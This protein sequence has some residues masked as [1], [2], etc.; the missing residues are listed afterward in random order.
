MS[1]KVANKH[2]EFENVEHALTASEAFI[3][4]YQ[5]QMLYGLG[6]IAVIV[7]GFL[8]ISNFY[9]K[10]RSTEAANEMYKSQM[11]FSKDSF[12]LALDGDGVESIGFEAISSDYS[13]T[14]SGN[15][16]KAY[17]G[18]CYYH[19]GKYE[20]AIKYLNAYDGDDKY[21]SI[22]VVGLIGDCYA[23]LGENEKAIKY[24]SN[25]A[26]TEND[27]L[28]PFYLKKAAIVYETTGDKEKA[29]ANYL[30]IK[31]EYPLSMESQDIDKYIARIQ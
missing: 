12:Q 21:F 1:N 16:A 2:D 22:T 15:L 18:I 31:E 25:A 26:G 8:A 5:K 10:P 6:A 9:I 4:K 27:V 11:Y 30:K 14:A 20:D 19:L 29:L 24:F 28:T 3:E 7:V 13:L 23:E 17:A